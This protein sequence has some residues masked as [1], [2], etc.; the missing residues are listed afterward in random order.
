MPGKK[1]CNLVRLEYKRDILVCTSRRVGEGGIR[2]GL[3]KLH[4]A[5]NLAT[6]VA[7]I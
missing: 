4:D 1:I 3:R 6:L 7:G 2:V 5:H